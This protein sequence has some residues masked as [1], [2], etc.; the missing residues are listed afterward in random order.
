MPIQIRYE[1]DPAKGPHFAAGL[2]ELEKIVIGRDGTHCQVVFPADDAPPSAG[3]TARW[4]RSPA[5]TAC[6]STRRTWFSATDGGSTTTTSCP[7]SGRSSCN[8]D[9][10]ARFSSFALPSKGSSPMRDFR[11]STTASWPESVNR[12]KVGDADRSSR[13]RRRDRFRRGGGRRLDLAVLLQTDRRGAGRA[14]VGGC[15]QQEHSFG[16][17]R[18]DSRQQ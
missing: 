11:T 8:L 7:S 6:G 15:A 12:P 1:G 5:A 13:W 16:L 17:S 10:P 18:P 2:E 4:N 9:V 3:N 14:A